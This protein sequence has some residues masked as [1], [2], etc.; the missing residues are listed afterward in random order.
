MAFVLIS[1]F[2]TSCGDPPPV[3]ME[4]GHTWETTCMCRVIDTDIPVRIFDEEQ[5]SIGV[6]DRAPPPPPGMSH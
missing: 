2:L 4:L 3:G 6:C 5:G 1:L